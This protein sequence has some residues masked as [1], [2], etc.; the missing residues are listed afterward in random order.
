MVESC[1]RGETAWASYRRGIYRS[2]VKQPCK[3]IFFPDLIYYFHVM[4]IKFCPFFIMTVPYSGTIRD[5]CC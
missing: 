2:D 1:Y 3:L 5:G 4:S